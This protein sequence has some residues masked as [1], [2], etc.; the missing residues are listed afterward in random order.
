[1]QRWLQPI[2][3]HVSIFTARDDKRTV[4][5]FRILTL[6]GFFWWV[7][8]FQIQAPKIFVGKF[9]RELGLEVIWRALMY[10]FM[11]GML[12]GLSLI[13]NRKGS[14]RGA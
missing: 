4:G 13:T 3:T 10:C 8:D 6:N 7:T 14:N 1:M 9:V 11:I 12:G 2:I 5:L